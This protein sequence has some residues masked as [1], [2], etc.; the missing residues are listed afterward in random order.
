MDPLVLHEKLRGKIG[1]I[2]RIKIRSK[3]DLGAIYTPGVALPCLEI[4]KDKS[5]LYNYT[6]KGNLVAIITDGSAVLGLGDIGPEASLP[7]MEGKAVLFKEFANIDAFPIALKTKNSDEIVRTVELLSPIFGGILLE[8]ISAPRCFEIE[9]KLNKKLDIPVFHDDQHGTAIV[10]LA[11]LY[12]SLKVVNKDIKKIKVV[13]NGAG[14]AGTAVA[15]LL[16]K[17]EI[18][19]ILVLDSMGII[20]SGRTKLNKYKKELSKITNHTKVNGNLKDALVDADVFIGLS[21]ANLVS[22][23]MVKTMNER[24]IIFAMANPIPEIMPELAKNSGAIIVATGRS[25][26]ANQI[27]NV[28]VF[29]GLFRGLLD[30]KIKFVDNKIKLAIAKA[31][32]NYIKKPTANN[33]IPDVLDKKDSRSNSMGK[34]RKRTNRTRSKKTN[35]KD[36]R[37]KK[38]TRSNER[39]LRKTKRKRRSRKAYRGRTRRKKSAGRSS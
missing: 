39:L 37:R 7:V 10:V 2:S 6:R 30:N 8:D 29:P 23:Q 32:A 25:D 16:V 22:G 12:N 5:K 18:K 24:A 14:A 4:K 3:A 38:K 17:A 21:K 27:N 31:L 9:E 20:Y 33:I 1:I 35:G 15:K 34:Q 36:K 13:V 19:N 28:L 11:G 26:F